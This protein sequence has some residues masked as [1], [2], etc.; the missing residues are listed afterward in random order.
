MFRQLPFG[1]Q[2]RR[3][4]KPT[5]RP[6]VHD[7]DWDRLVTSW[8]SQ[9]DIA[10]IEAQVLAELQ[11]LIDRGALDSAHGAIV[12]EY[13]AELFAREYERA[14]EEFD[15]GVH[16][17]QKVDSSGVETVDQLC[18]QAQ[19]AA[20]VA[21]DREQ[22]ADALY[23]EVVGLPRTRRDPK[24]AMDWAREAELWADRRIE[25]VSNHGV[26]DLELRGFRGPGRGRLGEGDD[27]DTG[28]LVAPVPA[29]DGPPAPL[30]LLH[31]ATSATS[32][33][34]GDEPATGTE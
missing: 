7:P 27:P 23:L 1:R 21:A 22:E 33:T 6:V 31:P 12:D 24:K 17:L 3:P 34:S 2:Q 30:R 11:R 16:Q 25:L 20:R 28:A 14:K 10:A 13:V 19:E 32:A 8:F 18:A 26:R 4:L 29:P 15:M 5:R 9:P